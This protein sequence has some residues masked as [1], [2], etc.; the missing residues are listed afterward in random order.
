MIMKKYIGTI[1][2]ILICLISGIFIYYYRDKLMPKKEVKEVPTVTVSQ[3]DFTVKIKERGSADALNFMMVS[4]PIS[5]TIIELPL[6]EGASVKKGD[7]ILKFDSLELERNLMDKELGYKQAVNDLNEVREQLLVTEKAAKLLIEE[8][9]AKVEFDKEELRLAKT[10]EDRVDRL[11]KEKISTLSK[12]EEQK[13]FTRSKQYM[14]E[15]S[16]ASLEYTKKSSSSDISKINLDINF[17]DTKLLKAKHDYEKAKNEFS[18]TIIK[19]PLDGIL[20]FQNVRKGVGQLD[21]LRQGDNVRKGNY[22]VKVAQPDSLTVKSEVKMEDIAEIKLGQK[23]SIIPDSAPEG[24]LEG[25]VIQI[26]SVVSDRWDSG[27]GKYPIEIEVTKNTDNLLKPGM[28][29]MVEV[30]LEDIKNAVTLPSECIYRD[31]DIL[32]VWLKTD[33][34]SFVKQNI[35]VSGRDEKK[36]VVKSGLKVGSIVALQDPNIVSATSDK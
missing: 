2:T 16:I 25:A 7:I 11:Y 17:A 3:E 28:Q 1:I 10:Q 33:K 12:F 29:V 22:I 15:K 36:S 14:L 20:I 8:Q 21:K 32:Y 26:S 34:G 9:E 5:G 31:G 27:V 35:T 23:V 4:A 18:K 6:K 19:S 30:T 24:R 13:R